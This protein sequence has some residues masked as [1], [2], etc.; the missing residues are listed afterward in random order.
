MTEVPM[1]KFMYRV[2]ATLRIADSRRLTT[3]Y[4]YY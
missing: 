2:A 3:P 1:K 4:V